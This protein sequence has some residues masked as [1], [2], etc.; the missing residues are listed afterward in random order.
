MDPNALKIYVDGSAY[1]NPGH[2]SGYAGIAVFPDSLDCEPKEIFSETYGASTNNRMELMGV[3]KALEYI[4]VNARSLKASRAIIITD[5]EYVC[6]NQNRPQYWRKDGWTGTNGVEVEN[7][8]LWAKYLTARTNV[9]VPTEIRWEAGKTTDILKKIDKAAKR[10][11]GGG[12]KKDDLGFVSGK[13]GKTKNKKGSSTQYDGLGKESIHVYRYSQKKT[14]SGI[15]YR[16]SFETRDLFTGEYANKFFAY[17]MQDI[18]EKIHRHG[19]Y[20]V[21]II[22]KDGLPVIVGLEVDT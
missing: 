7:K 20:R 18:F 17:A 4:R 13:I 9:S 15:L 22:Q 6:G 12:I 8:D 3:I 16:I 1:R 10:A 2:E 5:S 14:R 19:L 11:A 21:E